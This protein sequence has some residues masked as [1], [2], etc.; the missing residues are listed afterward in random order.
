VPQL[1]QVGLAACGA[2]LLACGR[3]RGPESV[4]PR[5]AGEVAVQVENHYAGT[6]VVY[7][8]SG[9]TSHRLGEVNFQEV[10]SFVLQWRRLWDGFYLR[11]EVIGSSERALTNDLQVQPGQMVRWTLTPNL[12]MS[13]VAIY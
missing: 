8:H 2:L 11:A 5:D 10:K 6:L 1:W 13:N 4:P 9:G 12:D 3:G 7:L